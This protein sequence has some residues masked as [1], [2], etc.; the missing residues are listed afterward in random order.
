MFENYMRMVGTPKLEPEEVVDKRLYGKKVGLINAASWIQLW[1]YYFGRLH[2]PG[3]KLINVGNEAV[4]L[5]FI[6]AHKN[7]LK[8]PPQENIDIFSNYANE[9]AQLSDGVD[10]I[11]ITCSTMNRSYESV[12]KSVEKF[13]IPVITI[14]QPMME[15]S[16]LMGGKILIIA[17]VQ[18]TVNSTKMLLEETAL[19]LGKNSSLE[20]VDGIVEQAFS[21]LGEGKITEHNELIATQIIQAQKKQKIDQVILAQLSMSVFTL[22]YPDPEKTFGVPVRTSGDEGFKRLKEIL[23]EQD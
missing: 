5:N 6:K 14:D 21:L 12:K 15:Q 17:T 19:S 10:A 20:Y 22:T 3:V 7:E 1:C 9:V 4:Q 2:I 8:C 18:T 16:V 13:N 11:M 23:L